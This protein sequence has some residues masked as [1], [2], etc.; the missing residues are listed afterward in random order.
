MSRTGRVCSVVSVGYR[1]LGRRVNLPR[2]PGGE[3]LEER[4]P[5]AGS[6][7]RPAVG[8][9]SKARVEGQLVHRRRE[10]RVGEGEELVGS[11][12]AL[13][14]EGNDVGHGRRLRLASPRTNRL[15]DESGQRTSKPRAE[16]R[17]EPPRPAQRKHRDRVGDDDIGALDKEVG[18]H[19]AEAP[20]VGRGR[21]GR[22]CGAGGV[23]VHCGSVPETPYRRNASRP[24]NG[25]E[26]SVGNS[27]AR[28]CTPLTVARAR[29]AS[30]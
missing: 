7:H 11:E 30:L 18:R 25:W 29:A 24:K 8:R 21:R 26:W 23:G 12:R 14:N 9:R 1:G 5:H 2:C 28:R 19:Q 10:R 22:L 13:V 17:L 15:G 4:P 16:V 3:R 20:L 27:V 6:H